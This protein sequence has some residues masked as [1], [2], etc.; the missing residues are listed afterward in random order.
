MI[1]HL[2]YYIS[3]HVRDIE[4]LKHIAYNIVELVY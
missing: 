4:L 1:N 3:K 2:I